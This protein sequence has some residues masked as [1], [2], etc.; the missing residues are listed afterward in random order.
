[1][2]QLGLNKTA[3]GIVG[4]VPDCLCAQYANINHLYLLALV[5]GRPVYP[6]VWLTWNLV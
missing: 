5:L 4:H 1:M 6:L 2:E 3:V